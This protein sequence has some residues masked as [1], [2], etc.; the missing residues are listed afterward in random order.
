MAVIKDKSNMRG[1]ILDFPKQFGIGLEA[2]NDIKVRG[3]FDAVLICGMGGSALPADILQIWLAA[4]KIGLPVF[5]HR[6]YG[7][8]EMADRNHLVVCISYSGNTE[9]TLDA[10]E[11]ARKRK[12]KVAA[13]TSGG[14][15]AQLCQQHGMPV[16][17]VPAGIPPRMSM[18]FLLAA[19]MK[20]L[21]NCG[22]ID[23]GLDNIAALEKSL[24]PQALEIE[25]QNLAK[26]I[27]S[28]A[29][30][31][32]ASDRLQSLA[33]IWKIKFNENSKMHSF[34]N[35]FPELNHNEINSFVSPAKFHWLILEDKTD[36]P[37]NQKR[38]EM[39][40]DLLRTR[41]FPVDIIEIKGKDILYKVFDNL[42]LADWT[43][44]YLALGLDYDPTPVEIVE[45][46][47]S[48]LK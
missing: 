22:I 32:Y 46:F 16:V 9:E 29:P 24:K 1:I 12:M 34:Y 37:Q 38:I 39:T 33:R 44:Y 4:Y 20:L 30:I 14:K 7:I 10:F 42:L 23:N 25:G 40:A 35:Y 43:S 13:I 28:K 6:N 31:I 19:L 2:A 15:L 3:K 45:E 48:K 36:L 41:G 21:V 18:G 47:K 5:I 27:K 8:P 11:E 17:M 26:K